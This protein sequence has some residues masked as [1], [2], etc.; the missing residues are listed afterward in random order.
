MAGSEHAPSGVDSSKLTALTEFVAED[1]EETAEV[2]EMAE[3]A[4]RFL[5]SFDWCD[6]VVEVWV[7]DVTADSV[8]AVFLCRIVADRD[9]VPEWLWVVV[10]D[11]PPAY[12]VVDDAPNP[13]SALDAYVGEMQE[14]VAAAKRGEPVDNLI[15]VLDADGTR[16]LPPTPETAEELERRLGLIDAEILSG[17]RDDLSHDGDARKR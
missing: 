10:G 6:D 4:A 12:V 16:E 11:V 13:A 8:V 15:P 5:R 7:G 14:W 3:R 9:G 1:E 2:R 17:C